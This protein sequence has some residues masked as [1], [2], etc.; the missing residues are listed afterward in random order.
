MS[1]RSTSPKPPEGGGTLSNDALYAPLSTYSD[2]PLRKKKN[3][4][5]LSL[6]TSSSHRESAL[7][8]FLTSMSQNL[9]TTHP[10]EG[11]LYR[12]MGGSIA[13][14]G[15]G[16]TDRPSNSMRS[17]L[18]G[19]MSNRSLVLF[20]GGIQSHVSAP[21]GS[22]KSDADVAN[23]IM[24]IVGLGI[25]QVASS[26]KR[27]RKRVGGNGIFGSISNKKRKRILNDLREK[28]SAKQNGDHELNIHDEEVSQQEK[29][30]RCKKQEQD[31]AIHAKVGSVVSTMHKMWI[32]YIR[33]LLA[34]VR[35]V[36]GSKSNDNLSLSTADRRQ[37]SFLLATAEHA[38]MPAT[39]VECQS[40][41]HLVH[42]RCMVV[43]ETKETWN[44]AMLSK[45]DWRRQR[46]KESR[47]WQSGS[48][49]QQHER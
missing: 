36:T 24:G 26:G 9:K 47:E 28:R 1:S 46:W 38:G 34:S 19:K 35:E 45:R 17:L 48:Q 20:G 7:I 43:N 29:P 30:G 37:I 31:A 5:S 41:R 21:K 44:I 14:F 39:V 40:R 10:Q 32:N 12:G 15:M 4:H 3:S 33:Q 2:G 42:T 6:Q 27:E 49:V 23:D 16:D 25:A 22:G 11:E 13:R 18:E 8:T